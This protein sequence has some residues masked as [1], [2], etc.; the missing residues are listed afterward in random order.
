VTAFFAFAVFAFAIFSAWSAA[1]LA[2]GVASAESLAHGLASFLS[3]LVAEFA[4][5]VGIEL[6][7]HS[8]THLFAAWAIALFAVTFR[9]LSPCWQSQHGCRE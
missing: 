2:I 8:L 5:A 4:V 9:R 7:E 6:L 3:F 1:V